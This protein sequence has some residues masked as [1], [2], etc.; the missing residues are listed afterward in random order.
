MSYEAM[1][2]FLAEVFQAAKMNAVSGH[3]AF[4]ALGPRRV[5]Q[6]SAVLRMETCLRVGGEEHLLY[7]SLYFVISGILDGKT[8]FFCQHVLPLL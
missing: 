2:D 3:R 7:Y 5:T 8:F 6:S 1:R 4:L